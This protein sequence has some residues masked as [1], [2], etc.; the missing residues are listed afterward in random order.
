[1][2]TQMLTSTNEVINFCKSQNYK[3]YPA[4]TTNLPSYADFVNKFLTE[5]A[6]RDLPIAQMEGNC[7]M[8][9]LKHHIEIGGVLTME[10]K[11]LNEICYA[12]PEDSI[13]KVEGNLLISSYGKYSPLKE[14]NPL[15]QGQ[16]IIQWHSHPNSEGNLSMNDVRCM[17]P[18]STLVE[19]L[20]ELEPSMGAYSFVLYL[21]HKRNSVWFEPKK[22]GL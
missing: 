17:A 21:P 6:E 2:A 3:F 20:R 16:D 19:R 18:I 9:N 13:V 15:Q 7:D 10:G 14:L 12:R 1:M 11:N 8:R 22:I 5:R 4:I